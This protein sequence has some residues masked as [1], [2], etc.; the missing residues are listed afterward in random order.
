MLAD[1]GIAAKSKTV[2]V[3]LF[4]PVCLCIILEA[5]IVYISPASL[6]SCRNLI[7]SALCLNIQGLNSL[8]GSV[9]IKPS[10]I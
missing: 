6:H 9:N 8:S 1:P 7:Y 4:Q 2:A 5:R 10:L 3:Y